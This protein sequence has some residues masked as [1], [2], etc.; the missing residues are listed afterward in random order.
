MERLETYW[1]NLALALVLMLAIIG[2]E[3]AVAPSEASAS[4][5]YSGDC[6]GYSYYYVTSRGY[7]RY[8]EFTYWRTEESWTYE[9]RSDYRWNGSYYEYSHSYENWCY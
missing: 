6:H 9:G 8:S 7:W 2:A 4:H 5:L 1:R 3:M